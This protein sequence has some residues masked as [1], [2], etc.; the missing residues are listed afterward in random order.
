L[1]PVRLRD[2]KSSWNLCLRER[3]QLLLCAF[4]KIEGRGG[5]F[6]PYGIIRDII[7]N[8]LMQV[9]TLIAM[10]LPSQEN[11]KGWTADQIRD[12]KVKVLKSMPVIQETDCLLGQYDSYSDDITI[13]NRETTTPTYACL[14]TWVN[15]DTWK[16]V[17]FFL[18][19]GKAL[20][21]H[22]CEARLYFRGST[23]NALVFR[24]Q[25]SPAVYFTANMKTPGFS[26]HPVSTHI[27][28]DYSGG[29]SLPEAYTKLVLE[30]L[31]GLQANFVRDDE[32][33]QAWKLLTPLLHR[34]E[35]SGVRPK[36]YRQGSTG[37]ED[38]CKFLQSM[39]LRSS[40]LPV[41]SSL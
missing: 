32:L 14:R 21:E 7:Q 1:E 13:D 34:Q 3:T 19:A 23:P 12:E 16:G 8:H 38:R 37:P 2:G 22:L 27:G 26:E 30:A 10:D 15:T 25:P 40:S 4:S 36:S 17:P 29:E 31:R 18:E 11:C 5:Y 41:P 33:L 24:L 6:D 20:D 39:G 28:V 9:L 35:A